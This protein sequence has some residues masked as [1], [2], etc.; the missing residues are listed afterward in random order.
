MKEHGTGTS[1]LR[2]YLLFYEEFS[3]VVLTC[4][5]VCSFGVATVFGRAFLNVRD[6]RTVEGPAVGGT[7]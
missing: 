5:L 2:R 4:V 7:Q 1:P 6:G 3:K